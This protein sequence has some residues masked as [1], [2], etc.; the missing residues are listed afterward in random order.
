MFCWELQNNVVHV[1]PDAHWD[2]GLLASE[3]ESAESTTDAETEGGLRVATSLCK[4]V[5]HGMVGK[6]S[7]LLADKHPWRC[8][9][10]HG[11]QQ[12]GDL[13]DVCVRF[14]NHC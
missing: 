7:I 6:R 10:P 4:A 13:W 5:N 11:T 12:C 14:R 8:V 1:S 9:L 2:V 3:L